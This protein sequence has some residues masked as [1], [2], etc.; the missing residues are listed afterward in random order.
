MKIALAQLNYQIENFEENFKKIEKAIEK[1]KNEKADLI[2]F[3]EL[4]VCGYYPFDLLEKQD[5]IKNCQNYLFKINEVAKKIAV[6]IGLPFENN[7]NIYNSAAF[8]TGEK[9]FH[10]INKTFL[11]NYDIFNEACYFEANNKFYT[12][13]YKD[14]KFAITIGDDIIETHNFY[15]SFKKKQFYK[16]SPLDELIK[17]KPDICINIS[18]NPFSYNFAEKK[19]NNL[20]EKSKKYSLPIVYVNQIG[21][22][23]DLIFDGGSFV[24]N[25]NGEVVK[26]CKSF[27]EDFQIF[28]FEKNSRKKEILICNTKNNRI[29]NIY[30]ALVLGIRDFFIKNKFKK[31]LLGLSGGIDSAVTLAIAIEAIGAKNVMSILMPTKFSSDHSIS[32][33]LEMVKRTNSPHEIIN[34]EQIRLHFLDC[35]AEIFTGK[36]ENITEENIQARIRGTI[37]MAYSNKFGNILLNTSNKSEFAVGYSTLYGDMNGSLSVLGDVYKTDVYNLAKYININKNNII[38]LNIITKIPSAELRPNQTDQDSLPPYDILDKIL[39]SYIEENLSK[40]E[41]TYFDKDTVDKVIK[42]VKNS[43]FKRFQAAPI[44]RVSSKAF[45]NGRKFPIIAINN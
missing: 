35:L 22:N 19:R 38:P 15:N 43:E 29:E 34:I 1:A 37:L 24:L 41:I 8:F 2:V 44:L 16:V 36:E 27:E 13:D 4:A 5:F 42:L 17:L 9:N 23:A 45:G 14:I 3:S 11:S 12:I 28:N 26:E 21:A 6:I 25:N 40:T 18:A 7:K 10:I 33:S 39:Y 30:N 31:A 32:D 20:I